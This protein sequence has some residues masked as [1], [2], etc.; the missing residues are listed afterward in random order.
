[1]KR[2]VLCAVA[3][4][5]M[6]AA[7]GR[8]QHDA[9][10]PASAI[11]FKNRAPVAHD[12]L[13]VTFPRPKEYT[14]PNGLKLMVLENHKLPTVSFNMSILAGSFFEPKDK[15]GLADMTA[16]M[17]DEGTKSRTSAEIADAVDRM[18]AS[19]G[20]AADQ[21]AERAIVRASGLSTD[22][23]AILDL[24]RDIIRNPT[25]P[26]D[27]FAKVKERSVAALT[28]AMQNP[29]ALAEVA[30][31]RAVYGDSPPSRVLPP[32][33][34]ITALTRDDLAAFHAAWYRPE[35]A[36]LGVVGDVDA[37][38]IY[39]MVREAFGDWERGSGPREARLPR[40]RPQN[41]AR[42]F[43]V[44]RPGSVQTTLRLGNLAINR[45]S[46][47]YA[48]FSVMNRIL[49]GG[50]SI[51]S[52]LGKNIRE[53]HGYTY[54]V[55]SA[56]RAPRFLGY[57]GAGTE[58]RNAVTGPTMT[59]FFNEFRRIQTDL[60]TPDELESAKRG[61]IGRF[62]LSLESP[63][64]LLALAMELEQFGLPADYWDKYPA[65]LESVTAEDVRRVAR[66]YIGE[67]RLQIVA[68]GERAQIA[69]ALKPYGPVTVLDLTDS[70][71]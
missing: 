8:A 10:A 12:T 17:L 52:R 42:V 25:F 41:R 5:A 61:L 44:E 55:Y 67:G 47:D 20:A 46:K 23:A 68:V 27:Q 11:E 54:D 51:S 38:A 29:D 56:F 49:G 32:I 48:A 15:Q 63:A 66:Q 43:L 36:L 31:M 24:F 13:R 35:R 9:P 14:L 65:L 53:Q 37:D 39:A 40:F 4:A 57:W 62:A 59:E 21:G 58:V 70:L 71:R 3:L 18:G 7:P 34:Q 26:A 19:L 28:Q 33:S 50:T 69:D 16:A 22:T 30:M 64:T 45:K 1:M 6:V 60:V 2:Y